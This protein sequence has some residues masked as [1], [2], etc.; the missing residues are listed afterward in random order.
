[1]CF[2]VFCFR[3]EGHVFFPVLKAMLSL[4]NSQMT[5]RYIWRSI[6]LKYHVHCAAV[7]LCVPSLAHGMQ[8]QILG[9]KR[10]PWDRLNCE[11]LLLRPDNKV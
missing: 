8:P 2:T 7:Q 6:K 9:H 11:V 5:L 1:M 3:S 10:K 4:E